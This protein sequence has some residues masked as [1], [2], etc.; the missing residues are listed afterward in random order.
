MPQDKPLDSQIF[1]LIEKAHKLARRYTDAVFA[2]E[3]YDITIDQWLTLKAI[4][5]KQ[6]ISQMEI[7]ETLFKDKASITRM[8]EILVRKKL[9]SKAS[10]ADKRVQHLALTPAGHDK[11]KSILKLVKSIRSQ[12]VK[13]MTDKEVAGL[14]TLL[15]KIISNM[16]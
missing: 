12:G 3:G 7:A 10:G 4:Y 16:T 6:E 8:L 13:N 11:V 5:D 9:V 15:E 14:K 1:Y 2:S